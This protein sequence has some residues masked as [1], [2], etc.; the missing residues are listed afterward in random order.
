MFAVLQEMFN[1]RFVIVL[2]VVSYVAQDF[3]EQRLIGIGFRLDEVI[4]KS[5]RKIDRRPHGNKQRRLVS[6]CILFERQFFQ[7]FDVRLLEFIFQCVEGGMSGKGI[8]AVCG[9]FHD[10]TNF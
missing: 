2:F 5:I 4:E 6:R 7:E 1:D 9:D 3:K 10:L 8:G